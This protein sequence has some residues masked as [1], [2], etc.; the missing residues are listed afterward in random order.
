MGWHLKTTVTH[1]RGGHGL[2]EEASLEGFEK[3]HK[4]PAHHKLMENTLGSSIIDVHHLVL[5][6]EFHLRQHNMVARGLACKSWP[7]FREKAH[8]EAESYSIVASWGDCLLWTL[9]FHS[10]ASATAGHLAKS[11][12]AAGQKW[13]G[14]E[15]GFCMGQTA[16]RLAAARRFDPNTLQ[17][18]SNYCPAGTLSLGGSDAPPPPS[19]DETSAWIQTYSTVCLPTHQPI[20]AST[21]AFVLLQSNTK[22]VTLQIECGQ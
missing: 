20:I 14:G 15:V 7:R 11:I 13:G 10:A 19:E 22:Q 6:Q 12:K 4:L 8:K 2:S 3:A 5:V 16:A 17:P 18:I 1:Q 9:N 21:A